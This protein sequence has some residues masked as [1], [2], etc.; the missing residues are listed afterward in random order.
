MKLIIALVFVLF[1]SIVSAVGYQDIDIDDIYYIHN[2][3]SSN[4]QVI[5]VKKLGEGKVKVRDTEAGDIEIVEIDKLLTKK[6][7]DGEVSNV[8]WGAAAVIGGALYCSSGN[9]CK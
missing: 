9:N 5:V 6:E 4:Q 2:S 7:L 1:S 8:G 3:F